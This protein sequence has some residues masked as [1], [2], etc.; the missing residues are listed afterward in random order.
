MKKDTNCGDLRVS[1]SGRQV[2][3]SG[4]VHRRRDHGG[5]VFLDLRDRSGL[6]QVVVNPEDAPEAHTE[7]DRVRSEWV[8]QIMGYVRARPSGT[9]NAQLPT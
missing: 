9:E 6:V 2:T 3:L 8:L 4:W 5:L 7:A 1:D